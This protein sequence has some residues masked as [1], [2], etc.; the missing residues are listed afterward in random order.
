[1]STEFGWWVKD[2]A[3]G[4]FQVRASVHGG[5]IEWRRK[6]GHHSSW[7]TH[8]PTPDDW[9]QLLYE[10]GKRVPR[11]LLSPKQFEEIRLLRERR[12]T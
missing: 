6:Q 7:E 12:G 10:A 2:P 4:K 11:R 1:M 3:Q 5:N 9:E 8:P